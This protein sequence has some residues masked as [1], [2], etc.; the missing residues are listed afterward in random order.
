MPIIKK[1]QGIRRKLS[2]NKA[3]LLVKAT[4]SYKFYLNVSF[5]V[6]SFMDFYISLLAFFTTFAFDWLFLKLKKTPFL[7]V[8]SLS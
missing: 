6:H 5:D 7:K 3:I 1:F 8:P 4:I 2:L